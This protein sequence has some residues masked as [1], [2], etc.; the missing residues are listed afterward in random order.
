MDRP[1]GRGMDTGRSTT[2]TFEVKFAD[3]NC[4]VAIQ[5]PPASEALIPEGTAAAAEVIESTTTTSPPTPSEVPRGD[6]GCR[7]GH[8]VD[9]D[10]VTAEAPASSTEAPTSVAGTILAQTEVGA[11]AWRRPRPCRQRPRRQR[12]RRRRPRRRPPRWPR[13]RLRDGGRS[14]PRTGASGL[15]GQLVVGHSRPCRRRPPAGDRRQAPSPLIRPIRGPPATASASPAS[16]SRGTRA[17]VA[18][19]RVRSISPS[20]RVG[21]GSGAV[22]AQAGSASPSCSTS[23]TAG[24]L[25]RDSPDS[26]TGPSMR[27]TPV[28][29]PST[30]SPTGAP[31]AM[32]TLP[33]KPPR[34]LRPRPVPAPE[35][36]VWPQGALVLRAAWAAAVRRPRW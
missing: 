14:D 23:S 25:R 22:R 36:R 17:S 18:V 28:D 29:R 5:P 15:P 34:R 24:G 16:C 13:R 26:R 32:W 3:K 9:N 21:P 19:R 1:A 31:T 6:R 4:V 12:P 35:R 2:A 10:D 30:G 33:S 7:R 20:G 27:S 8:R 11:S